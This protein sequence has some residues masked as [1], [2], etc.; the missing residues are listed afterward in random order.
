MFI[1]T[2]LSI[3]VLLLPSWAVASWYFEEIAEQSG[4]VSTHAFPGPI[5]RTD[6]RSLAGGV[7]IGDF[8]ADGWHDIFLVGGSWGENK[9][10]QNQRDGTFEDVTVAARLDL[11]GVNST[12]P[13]FVDIDG[14][15]WLDLFVLSVADDGVSLPFAL[16]RNSSSGRFS[17][18]ASRS[19]I[20]L[21]AENVSS[22]AF[23][24]VDSDGDLD[25]FVSHGSSFGS[26][27]L[28]GMLWRNDGDFQFT[29]V[30]QAAG[31]DLAA[32]PE[33][34]GMDG[35]LTPTFADL[36]GDGFPDLLLT[37][38]TDNPRIFMNQGDGTFSLQEGVLGDPT[39]GIGSATGDYD[40]DG[41]L[42]VFITGVWDPE[43]F[44]GS[45]TAQHDGNRLYRNAG[46]GSFVDVTTAAG[47]RDGGWGVA[48]ASGDW[49]LDGNLDL[50]VVNGMGNLADGPEWLPF[51]EDP[52]RLFVSNG[53]GSFTD[54]AAFLGV[55]DIEMG[56]ATGMV[57]IDRDG[58]ID[59][60]NQN[61]MAA[62]KL[63]KNNTAPGLH[64]LVLKLIGRGAN[65][66]AIGARVSVTAGG[67]TQLRELQSGSSFGSAHANEANFGLGAAEVVEE[68][69][70]LWPDRVESVFTN[71]AADQHLVLR[72]PGPSLENCSSPGGSNVCTLG[73]KE[74]S[75][76][77][78]LMELRITPTP[79]NGRRAGPG[80]R[81]DCQAGDSSCDADPDDTTSCS[82]DVAIC[83]SN[84]DP[85]NFICAPSTI[86]K[87][88]LKSPNVGSQRPTDQS[89]IKFATNLIG[90]G[91]ASLAIVDGSPFVPLQPG[92]CSSSERLTVPLR[93]KSSGEFRKNNTRVKIQAF[94]TDGRRDQDQLLVRCSPAN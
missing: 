39:R 84:D 50:Y 91:V 22:P 10:F 24:D 3:L 9:L 70:V 42:D 83:L 78:C 31:F 29:D 73:G 68:L 43:G 44:L 1:P 67:V 48:A 28:G 36:N 8:N 61:T 45:V 41:D 32:H 5:D 49:N 13:I 94:A 7:A 72:H 52:A 37:G 38:V 40:N 75:P 2:A 14:D 57:D 82:L 20:S 12:G 79:P 19:G 74:R 21:D 55:A 88:R 66:E 90:A 34:V 56:R 86:N 71:L 35:S 16:Y 65:R 64:F 80:Y 25:L 89:T 69:R 85:R 54:Q 33:L 63:Y 77:E 76:M 4:L 60:V 46:D 59:L 27:P 11:S 92:L 53:A 18:V 58:D 47:V 62:A 93:Q 17:N 23:A 87:L 15:G 51:I 81:I 26:R 30:T 6:P